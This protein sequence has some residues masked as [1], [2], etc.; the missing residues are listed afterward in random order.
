VRLY[1]EDAADHVATM[2]RSLTSQQD[3]LT[4]VYASY[5]A[6]ISMEATEGS[7]R[8]NITVKRVWT[9][10]LFSQPLQKNKNK[11][12][13]CLQFTTIACIFTPVTILGSAL[14]ENIRVP[15]E[16]G[17]PNDDIIFF[18]AT[19]V[20]MGS[21]AILLLLIGYRFKWFT[22]SRWKRTQQKTEEKEPFPSFPFSFF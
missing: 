19:I 4:R 6:Q 14:G 7:N 20:F 13:V 22:A 10:C 15:F 9:I 16:L 18:W 11:S 21:I 3:T 5:L 12:L 1:L 2:E 17:G 8:S